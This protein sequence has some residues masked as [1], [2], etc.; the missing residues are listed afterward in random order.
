[1]PARDTDAYDVHFRAPEVLRQAG[2]TVIFSTG[3]NSASLVKNLPYEAAQAVAFGYPAAEAVKGLTLYPARVA[4]MADR[5]GSIETGKDATFFAM[6]GDVLDIR[7][8]VKRMWI[9]GREVSLESRHTRLYEKYRHRP[10]PR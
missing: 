8:N 2:V 7:A 5:L 10:K 9:A 1:L 4:G 3:V 6:D